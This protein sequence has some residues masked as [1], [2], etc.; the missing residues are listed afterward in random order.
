MVRETAP[1]G[2]EP[3]SGSAGREGRPSPFRREGLW[4]RVLPFAGIAVLAEGSILLPPGPRSAV[5]AY[6]SLLLLLIVGGAFLLP[7][8]RLPVWASVL[9]PLTYAG[10]V[11]ALVLATNSSASGLGLVLMV[12][13]VWTALFHRPWESACVVTAVV[14]AALVMSYVPVAS[15]DGV[16]IRR[17]F[18]WAA[19]GGVVSVSIHALRD[20]TRRAEHLSASL[21]RDAN[22][23]EERD[24]IAQRVRESTLHRITGASL[25]LAGTI[26]QPSEKD[27][28]A[29]MREVLQDLDEVVAELRSAVY[30]TPNRRTAR[31]S[32]FNRLDWSASVPDHPPADLE[33]RDRM[34]V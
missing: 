34:G 17:V 29:R 24:R 4:E 31:V 1:S 26:G 20:R 28:N 25:I 32:R 33:D 3:P 19:V 9:V 13:V 27:V 11:L 30:D 15:S 12:P 16:V 14:T 10:S 6:V 8:E 18:L 2:V 22:V 23:Q 21:Q 7:W 5:G